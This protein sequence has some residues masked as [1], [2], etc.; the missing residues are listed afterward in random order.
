MIPDE[1]PQKSEKNKLRKQAIAARN[2]QPNRDLLS[3]EILSRLEA[4]L[5]YQQARSV[6]F[7][8]DCRGEVQ[9]RPAIERAISAGKMVAVP[10]CI[11]RREMELFRLASLSELTPGR[12]AIDEPSAEVRSDPKRQ[13]PPV[14]IDLVVV[15][16]VAFDRSGNRLGH[17]NGYYDRLLAQTRPNVPRVGLAFE[18]QLVDE[19]P[20]EPHDVRMHAVITEVAVYTNRFS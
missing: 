20:A 16:G 15:P 7:Y 19:L 10:W 6:A 14:E 9:T 2:A 4:M 1:P 11:D 3:R 5:Q 8:V 17:G 18:C 12:F 13:I